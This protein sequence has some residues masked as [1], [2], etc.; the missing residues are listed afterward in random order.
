MSQYGVSVL[1]YT[2]CSSERTGYIS[3]LSSDSSSEGGQ[4]L[5]ERLMLSEK[6]ECKDRSGGNKCRNEGYL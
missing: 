4:S 3:D 5:S 6:G 1:S 2:H